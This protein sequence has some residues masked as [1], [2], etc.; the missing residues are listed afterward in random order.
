MSVISQ[1]LDDSQS[2]ESQTLPCV[3]KM[4]ASGDH[5]RWDEFVRTTAGG[6]FYHLSGWKSLFEKQLQ[7]STYYLFCE[8]AGQ[9]EA[10]LP[11]VQV[12]SLLFGNALISIPF[13]VYGGAVFRST[14]ALTLLTDAASE[15]AIELGVDHVE[16]RMM[17]DVQLDGTWQ[18]LER[19]ATFRK[20]ID[21]DPEKNLMAIPRKQRAMVRKGIKAGLTAE[22]DEKT[23]RLY[24]AM[25]ACK[26]NLG[27][28]FFGPSWLQ[29]IK[30]EFGS[31]VEIMT[32]VHKAEVV[33][34]VM[35]FRFGKEILPYYGGGGDLARDLKGNDFMYWS[36][37]KKA[38]EENIDIFD[39]GRS[40]IGSGAYHFKKHWGFEPEI[41]PYQYRLIRSDELPNLNP[42][43][44]RFQLMIKAWK[45]LPLSVAGLIGPP[46]ARRL[47]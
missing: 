38:C 20:S 12:K 40:M 10:I 5:A 23:D 32:I 30:E 1:H 7:H 13:L 8:K 4:L 16:L 39:Y 28:P 42:S 26:R 25:R 17:D 29:A 6:T 35:S 9:I 19:Y 3:V 46:I 44:S 41:L 15:L 24:L 34:S 37:M 14:V 22:V 2:A 18:T 47:G 36:V 45:M 33:C 21:S 11:L 27:T 43:N 31:D